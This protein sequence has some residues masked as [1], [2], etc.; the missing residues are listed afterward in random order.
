MEIATT[1]VLEMGV[2][3]HPWGWFAW[4][5]CESG[6]LSFAYGLINKRFLVDYGVSLVHQ[7][8]LQYR[9]FLTEKIL[10]DL[11]FKENKKNQ[12]F[13]LIFSLRFVIMLYMSTCLKF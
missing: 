11:E 6:S 13:S 4:D 12:L 8:F 9:K 10:L 2:K 3:K 5:C 7:L 1:F